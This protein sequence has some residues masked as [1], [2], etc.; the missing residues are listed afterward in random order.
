MAEL[1]WKLVVSLDPLEADSDLPSH[2]VP[3]LTAGAEAHTAFWWET[4]HSKTRWL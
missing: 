1:S 4:N 3:H 2:I